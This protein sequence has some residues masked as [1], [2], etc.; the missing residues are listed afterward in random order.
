LCQITLLHTLCLWTLNQNEIVKTMIANAYKARTTKDRLDTNIPLSVQPWGV[1]GEKRRYWLVEGQNDTHF[2]VYRETDPHKTKKVKWFSVAGGM[3]DLKL[4]ATKLEEE[5]GRKDAKALG[6][7]M[8]NAIPRFEAS[9]VVSTSTYCHERLLTRRRSASVAN[10]RAT[11][12]RPSSAPTPASPSTKAARA[13]SA[14]G[15]HIQTRRMSTQT[16]LVVLVAL[17]GHRVGRHPPSPPALPS[18]PAVARSDLAPPASTA[19]HYSADKLPTAHHRRLETMYAL[20]HLKSR[21]RLTH[22]V[23]LPALPPMADPRAE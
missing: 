7:R 11:V 18:P 8:L 22:M 16:T 9:E 13:A 21:G 12:T 1:D 14:N 23:A 2:R 10:T 6:E 5:D 15:T 20:M 17:R 19:R 3:D 4:V